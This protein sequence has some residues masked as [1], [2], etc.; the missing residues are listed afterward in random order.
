MEIILHVII[1][2]NNLEHLKY[3]EQDNV[4]KIWMINV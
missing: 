2:A 1:M 3:N 4:R